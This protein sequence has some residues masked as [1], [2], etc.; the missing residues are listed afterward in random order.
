MKTRCKFAVIKVAKHGYQGMKEDLKQETVTLW[1]VYGNDGENQS[2]AAAT[3]CGTLDITVTNPAVIGT[4]KL[5]SCYY[6]DLIP[7]E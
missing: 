1:A 6:L 3:P 2:F 4:F 7:A 5:G